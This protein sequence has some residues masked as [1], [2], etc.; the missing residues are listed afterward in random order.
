[1]RVVIIVDD[2]VIEKIDPRLEEILKSGK[3]IHY[4]R[5]K[6]TVGLSEGRMIG[7][8]HVK[9]PYFLLLDDDFIFTQRTD[10]AKLFEIIK[11]TNLGLVAGNTDECNFFGIH[12]YVKID[13]SRVLEQ[14]EKH[15]FGTL[16]DHPDCYHVDIAKNFFVGK[17]NLVLEVG[18]WT[19]YL[20]VAEHED[21]FIK[22]KLKNIPVAVCPS[23]T[24]DHKQV[25]D[26][27]RLQRK[28]SYIYFHKLLKEKWKLD[29]IKHL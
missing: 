22:L 28:Y 6:K 26:R 10:I 5:L 7:L 4:E 25:N 17:L 3:P 14:Y 23:V 2:Y 29:E 11:S 20:M 8:S 24:I 9:T 16:K 19:R 13:K 1:M 12:K 18:G 21:L 27:I 15:S